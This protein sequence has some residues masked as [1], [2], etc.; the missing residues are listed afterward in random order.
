MN[1]KKSLFSSLDISE[2]LTNSISEVLKSNS[3]VERVDEVNMGP[4]HAAMQIGKND[5]N[6]TARRY[7]KK[8]PEERSKDAFAKLEPTPDTPYR[9]ARKSVIVGR[10]IGLFGRTVRPIFAD[11]PAQKFKKGRPDLRFEES[12][13]LNELSNQTLKNYTHLAANDAANKALKAGEILNT[14]LPGYMKAVKKANSRLHG[15]KRALTKI[16]E[17]IVVDESLRSTPKAWLKKHKDVLK[18]HDVAG[19]EYD[20]ERWRTGDQLERNPKWDGL[21]KASDRLDRVRKHNI[22]V[23]NVYNPGLDGSYINMKRGPKAK[24]MDKAREKI[25]KGLWSESWS[26]SSAFGKPKKKRSSYVPVN[27]PIN[28]YLPRQPR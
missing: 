17:D 9:P 3:S 26:E 1:N 2:D 22:E 16:K 12:V 21:K 15:V 8:T 11:L 4:I 13:D 25:R 20:S 28:P 24:A 23:G 6:S 5:R 18:Q 19:R 7:K 27:G 10:N 14:N